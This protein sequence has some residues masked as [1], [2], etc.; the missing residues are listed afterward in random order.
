MYN[1]PK[2]TEVSK[3]LQ[4]WVYD[5]KNHQKLLQAASKDIPEYVRRFTQDIYMCVYVNPMDRYGTGSLPPEFTSQVQSTYPVNPYQKSVFT[6]H[7]EPRPFSHQ[8]HETELEKIKSEMSQLQED[9][10]HLQTE[11]TEQDKRQ[12]ETNE[13]A[14]RR[15]DEMNEAYKNLQETICKEYQKL[16]TDHQRLQ[17]DH[18][19]VKQDHHTLQHTVQTDHQQLQIVLK[20]KDR[21]YQIEKTHLEEQIRK[22]QESWKVSHKDVEITKE[23]LGRG[24]WGV[25]QVGL[26]REQRV[27]VKQLY[28]VIMSED[29]LTLMH[30]EINNLFSLR[31]RVVAKRYECIDSWTTKDVR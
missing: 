21:D 2:V 1:I 14:K 27:A 25:I 28:K 4:H 8:K 16:K 31:F 20:Q 26:F 6:L 12:R 9:N 17:Q 15:E 13:K 18:E 19:E 29:N 23:E 22:L 30:R 3:D 5:E 7:E 10:I 24:G 11:K